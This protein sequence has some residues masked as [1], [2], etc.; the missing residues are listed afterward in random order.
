MVGNLALPMSYRYQGQSIS[1]K[2]YTVFRHWSCLPNLEKS[3]FTVKRML[4]V[5]RAFLKDDFHR[6]HL[7]IDKQRYR[8]FKW[9]TIVN[10]L[11]LNTTLENPHTTQNYS[12][13]FHGW[14]CEKLKCLKWSTD[15]LCPINHSCKKQIL[16][17]IQLLLAEGLFRLNQKAE[18]QLSRTEDCQP[19][20][21]KVHVCVTPEQSL[22]VGGITE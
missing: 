7:N 17:R 18:I 22:F 15:L 13:D 16:M 10:N 2:W 11:Y 6:D 21:F 5:G 19:W 20:I 1:H 8:Q 3:L 14:Q 9:L 4:A 12:T